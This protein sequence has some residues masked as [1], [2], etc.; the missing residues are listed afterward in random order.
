MAKLIRF[1]S[2]EDRGAKSEYVVIAA[3]ESSEEMHRLSDYSAKESVEI[4]DDAV[5]MFPCDVTLWPTML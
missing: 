1:V 3:E 4:D 2:D 5:S